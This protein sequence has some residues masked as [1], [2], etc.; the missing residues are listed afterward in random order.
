MYLL[1]ILVSDI[2]P[3]NYLTWAAD[4]SL[5]WTAIMTTTLA[6]FCGQRDLW[7]GSNDL[8]L[9]ELTSL[10]TGTRAGQCDTNPREYDW[11]KWGHNVRCECGELHNGRIA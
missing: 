11:R 7:L 8:R 10:T 1:G 4:F 3:G 2:H 9:M 6:I 5:A